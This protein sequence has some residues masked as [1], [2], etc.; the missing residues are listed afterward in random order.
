MYVDQM[1]GAS[2]VKDYSVRG[3]DREQ[4]FNEWLGSFETFEEVAKFAKTVKHDWPIVC[5][6][7]QGLETNELYVGGKSVDGRCK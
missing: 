3:E 2:Q 4:G 7:F 5:Y 6:E 1:K